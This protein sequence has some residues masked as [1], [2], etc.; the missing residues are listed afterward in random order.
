MVAFAVV[1]TALDETWSVRETIDR[2]V[3][4]NGNDVCDIVMAIAPHTTAACR[5]VIDEM[6]AKY[7]DLVR[8]HEQSRLPGVGGA[9][10]E[11]AELV[12]A[13]WVI[14]MAA[15]LETPP[16]VGKRHYCSRQ[17]R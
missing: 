8:C 9:N 17:T 5:A 16:G 10:Q 11:C 6:E 1:I 2:V 13:E 7:P 4:D 14:F 15:D 12:Q 3:T